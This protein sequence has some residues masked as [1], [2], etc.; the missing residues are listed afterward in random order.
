MRLSQTR[1]L[2]VI[3]S[4]VSSPDQKAGGTAVLAS[5]PTGQTTLVAASA[6]EQPT[7]PKQL[8]EAEL[9]ELCARYLQAAKISLD[10]TAG[11]MNCESKT[12]L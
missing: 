2:Q 7:P 12:D 11:T 6:A 5:S 1:L 4:V 10:A 9:K 8:D 3:T